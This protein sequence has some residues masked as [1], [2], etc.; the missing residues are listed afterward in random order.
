M[1]V[2]D[3]LTEALAVFGPNISTSDGPEWARQ[4]KLTATPFN[5]RN[6]IAVWNESLGQAEEMLKLW[7]SAPKEGFTTTANDTRTLA[8]HV[9]AYAAFQKSYPFNSASKAGVND[10]TSM[11]YRDALSIILKNAM[12][13]LVVPRFSFALPFMPVGWKRI[14]W[15]ISYF[16]EYMMSQV[17]T[18]K[19]LQMDGKAGSGNLV[20]NLVRASSETVDGSSLKPLT[21]SEILGNIFVYNFAGHDTTAI[22]NAY[23]MLLLVSD[24][25]VQDWVHEELKYYLKDADLKSISYTE[26]FPKLKRC[27]AVL[28]SASIPHGAFSNIGNISLT[29]LARD[30]S[31]L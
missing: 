31:P 28:V 1:R 2:S 30:S 12:V 5:E 11:T 26:T 8:L 14:G 6:N 21:E 9:L 18:E 7:C 29:Y 20:S 16:R 4:R 17:K 13:V 10:E 22:S 24:P 25:T 27:Q 23:G 15:A 19:S 3:V